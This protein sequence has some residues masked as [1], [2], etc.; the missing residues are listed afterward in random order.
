MAPIGAKRMQ[1]MRNVLAV[2]NDT[3]I[4]QVFTIMTLLIIKLEIPYQ[5]GLDG[6]CGSIKRSSPHLIAT[7]VNDTRQTFTMG[8]VL[9]GVHRTYRMWF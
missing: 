6:V 3:E 7:T 4:F 9:L 5:D 2:Q 8:L 1:L